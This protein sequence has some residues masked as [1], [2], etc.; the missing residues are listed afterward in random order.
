MN[1]RLKR[2]L[3]SFSGVWAGGYYSGDPLDPMGAPNFDQVGYMSVF[4]ATYLTCIRPYVGPD[5]VAFEIGPGRGSWTK[6]LLPAR[7]VWVVDAL[8]AEHNQFFEYLGH[9]DNVRYIQVD[10]FTLRD[11][12][13]DHFNFMFSYGALC[14]ASFAGITEY[15]RAALPKL[16]SGAHCFWMVADYAKYNAAVDALPQLSSWVR[17]APPGRRY[18][19]LQAILRRISK[20]KAPGKLTPDP[21]DEPKPGRWYDAGAERTSAMLADVGYRVVDSDVGVNHRDPVI[22]FVKP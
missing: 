1:D 7:E 12:P 10:D 2:E 18:R 9:P 13:D 6:A 14:H 21:D 16:T 19:P 20:A 5:T 17:C 22:H 4:H 15:A 11:L 3:D 8:S